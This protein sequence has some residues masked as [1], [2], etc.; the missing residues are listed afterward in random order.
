MYHI[1]YINK[2]IFK[3]FQKTDE[4]TT[5]INKQATQS[6]ETTQNANAQIEQSTTSTAENINTVVKKV[7]E[8]GIGGLSS[9]VVDLRNK[10]SNTENEIAQFSKELRAIADIEIKS[11]ISTKLEKDIA[12]AKVQLN[13]L[14]AEAVANAMAKN[15][16]T[17]G[18]DIHIT[19]ML[20][21]EVVA[22][23]V[24]KVNDRYK[25]SHGKS[26]FT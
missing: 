20:E 11:D 23:H 4:V 7:S 6:V 12:K 16:G 24:V 21:D 10:I 9:K 25:K 5:N 18:G 13:S 1:F 3:L 15:G 14:Y 2:S 26:M 17:G 8:E 19:L 22:K